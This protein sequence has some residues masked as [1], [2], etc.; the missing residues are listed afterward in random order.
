[1]LNWILR[2]LQYC[3][4]I[5]SSFVESWKNSLQDT[6]YIPLYR[7]SRSF[8]FSPISVLFLFSELHVPVLINLLSFS[9]SFSFLTNLYSSF[10]LFPPLP[11]GLVIVSIFDSSSDM[12]IPLPSGQLPDRQLVA[13][14]A[15]YRSYIQYIHVV[16]IVDFIKANERKGPVFSR[17]AVVKPMSIR[18]RWSRAVQFRRVREYVLFAVVASP[19]RASLRDRRPPDDP[20]SDQNEIFGRRAD[21]R[22]PRN[23]V[24]LRERAQIHLIRLRNSA[25]KIEI[26][27]TVRRTNSSVRG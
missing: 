9:L 6:L 18:C 1:M 4:K 19:G 23:E 7:L 15:R 11:R 14:A 5:D 27:E 12:L 3:D 2:A 26:P 24:R 16:T 21:I 22:C 17:S 8:Y 25:D 20:P 13:S 10:S